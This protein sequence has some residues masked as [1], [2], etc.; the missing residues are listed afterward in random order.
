MTQIMFE[1]FNSPAFYTSINSVLSIYASGRTTGVVVDSGDGVTNVV[2]IYEGFAVPRA[3]TRL[4]LAGRDLTDYLMKILAERGYA[5]TTTAERE[6]V[7][8]IKE[9]LC[10]TALDF[11]KELHA[12]WAAPTPSP[13]VR[14]SDAP[15]LTPM[16]S[17]TA[18]MSTMSTMRSEVSD[19]ASF[20]DLSTEGLY[21]LYQDT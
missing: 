21:F 10:Y 18:T 9:K 2:P 6:I 7:R 12:G 13:S 8:D 19:H 17:R 1:T 5:F 14:E 16:P 3:I 4:E 20:Y 11:E 15:D